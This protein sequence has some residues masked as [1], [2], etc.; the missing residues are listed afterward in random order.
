[1]S[2][3]SVK[4]STP[5]RLKEFETLSNFD[6]ISSEIEHMDS[7]KNQ[8]VNMD[9]LREWITD[10]YLGKSKSNNI[11]MKY[12]H[13]IIPL[14]DVKIRSSEEIELWDIIKLEEEK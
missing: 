7:E 11:K 4:N 10:L 3:H 5:R 6:G 9:A 8:L 2:A 1:M 14:I 13:W 12:S